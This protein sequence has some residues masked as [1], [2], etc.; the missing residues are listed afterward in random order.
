ME[1][2]QPGERDDRAEIGTGQLIA[3]AAAACGGAAWLFQ[4]LTNRADEEPTEPIPANL[5]SHLHALV[6]SDAVRALE[7]RGDAL[8]PVVQTYRDRAGE[9]AGTVNTEGS[10]RLAEAERQLGHRRRQSAAVAQDVERQVADR[11][12]RARHLI[13]DVPDRI[14]AVV[15]D[16]RKELRQLEKSIGD[17]AGGLRQSTSD[18]T[19]EVTTMANEHVKRLQERGQEAAGSISSTL[20]DSSKDTAGRVAD[21]REQVVSLARS[22]TRDVGSLI[23]DVRDDARRN[24][25]DVAKVLTERASGIGH[26]VA[27]GAT[28]AGQAIGERAAQA[29]DRVPAGSDTA[30]RTQSTIADVSQRAA[31]IAAPALG[32]IGDRLGHLSGDI[33]DD[34]N[35]VRERLVGQGQGALKTIQSQVSRSAKDAPDAGRQLEILQGRATEARDRGLDLTALLQSNIPSFLAQV[36]DLIEQAGDKSGSRVKD[37][38]KQSADVVGSAEDQVQSAIDRLGEAAR[39]AAQVG[40]QAVAASS[41]LRGASRNAAHRTADAGKDGLE[42]IIWLGAAGVAMYYGILNPEQR[43]TVNKYGLKV[44]RGLGRVIGEIRGRDQKF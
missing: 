6:E 1:N 19:G 30:S 11:V 20:R 8:V 25:P 42:S 26:Q 12:G 31:A 18:R 5:R 13:D 38:R 21:V 16:G 41:H 29:G 39:R 23:H 14:S 3:I 43:A 2:P 24:L 17:R 27:E 15:G 7:R 37:V 9:I 34:P 44:G 36:T 32:V 28:R 35:G 10:K 40:D 4:K 22:S 33:R